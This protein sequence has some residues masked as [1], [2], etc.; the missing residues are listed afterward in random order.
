MPYSLLK[1]KGKDFILT[2]APCCVISE[3]DG[4]KSPLSRF[5]RLPEI[6]G[7]RE[8][9]IWGSGKKGKF[10]ILQMLKVCKRF[11]ETAVI[12][13]KEDGKG[14]K[15]ILSDGIGIRGIIVSI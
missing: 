12:E 14:S 3:S 1:L 4:A 10:V 7:G 6:E 8:R 2:K 11:D 5:E 9:K 13:T 15:I